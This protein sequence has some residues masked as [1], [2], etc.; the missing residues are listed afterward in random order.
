MIIGELQH[1]SSC[2]RCE[3]RSYYTSIARHGEYGYLLLESDRVKLTLFIPS[4]RAKQHAEQATGPPPTPLFP[5][6]P[7]QPDQIPTI[8][9]P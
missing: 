8:V 9:E 7:L 3:V 6:E 5:D 2:L 4:L 1:R